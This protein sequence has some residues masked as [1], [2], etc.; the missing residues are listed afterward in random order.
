[1]H[2]DPGAIADALAIAGVPEATGARLFELR[3]YESDDASTLADK[4]RMFNEGEIAIFQK[5]GLMPV[6]FGETVIGEKQPNLTYLLWYDSLAARE[7]NWNKFISSPEW[8]KLKSTPG[9]SD[10]EIVSNI[11]NS[12]LRPMAFSPIK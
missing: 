5:T 8:T 1:M 3:T 7:A 6:F 4:I 2:L 9:W 11:S 10:A 12:L